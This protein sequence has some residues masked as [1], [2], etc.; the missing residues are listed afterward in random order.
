VPTTD[1]SIV[2][3][4]DIMQGTSAPMLRYLRDTLQFKDDLLY[5]GPFGEA[6][7]PAPLTAVAPQIWGPYT[8]WMTMKWNRSPAPASAAGAKPVRGMSKARVT[9][10]ESGGGPPFKKPPPLRRAMDLNPRLLV[11]N[12]TGMYDSYVGSCAERE[13]AVARS[14]PPLRARVRNACYEAGHEVYT[15]VAVRKAFQRDFAQ[16]VRDA[17]SPARASGATH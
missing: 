10:P 16:F 7:H 3:Q 9:G 5:A 4:L 12:V 1:P 14:E 13:E 6:F 8:D 2:P 15:D 17:A 11:M